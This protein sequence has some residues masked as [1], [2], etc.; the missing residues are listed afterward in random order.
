MTDAPTKTNDDDFED[1][2]L[3]EEEKLLLE[4]ALKNLKVYIEDNTEHYA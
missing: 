2:E 3:T 1:T 4:Q